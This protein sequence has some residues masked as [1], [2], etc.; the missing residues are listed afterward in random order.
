MNS[1]EYINNACKTESVNFPEIRERVTNEFQLRLLHSVMGISTE[2]GELTEALKK[3]I[4][5]G[6]DLDLINLKESVIGN[7]TYAF[8][9]R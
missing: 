6:K 7:S 1:E 5:F 3:F 2:A 8:L 4:F 9:P